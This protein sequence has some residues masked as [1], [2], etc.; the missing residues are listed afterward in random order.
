MKNET[1]YRDASAL[2]TPSK[3]PAS[4]YVINPYIGC[5][6]RCK[7]CY[8]S[9]MGRFTGHTEP[10]GTYLEPKKYSSYKLPGKIDSSKTILI[11][12]VTDAYNPSESKYSLMPRILESLQDCSAHVEIL[13]KSSLVLRDIDLI[14]QIP[15]IAVGV[16]LSNLNE[17][18]NEVLEPGA[19]SAEARLKTLKELHENKI[20]TYLFIA[21]YLPGITNLNALYDAVEGAVDYI[22]V[23]NLNLRGNY[24]QPM[25][26][27]IQSLHPDLR[28]L[29]DDIYTKK[30]SGVYW[31]AIEKQIEALRHKSSVP[32]I[33]YMYHEKI[34]KS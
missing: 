29:W 33:S 1:I 23:E 8:A 32:I 9:F 5:I 27:A 34:K 25:L 18:D 19:S 10:W 24:K 22:C 11:G 15:D 31:A 2:C 28:G 13:T 30:K 4:D 3:L 20:R 14:K 7:Y 6:H 21:P 17:E 12:S 16:S 26:D